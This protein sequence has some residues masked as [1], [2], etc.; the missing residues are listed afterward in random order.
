MANRIGIRTRLVRLSEKLA[1]TVRPDFLVLY[2]TRK[3]GETWLS[4]QKSAG[5]E[6]L[7]IDLGR[8]S[9][10]RVAA[11]AR[12]LGLLEGGWPSADLRPL[13]QTRIRMWA[14][15]AEILL[16]HDG[17]HNGGRLENALLLAGIRYRLGQHPPRLGVKSLAWPRTL[18]SANSFD[19]E[20]IERELQEI[21]RYIR[22]FRIEQRQRKEQGSLEPGQAAT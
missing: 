22:N 8:I 6:S 14:S 18:M 17:S 3:T 20:G 10:N 2:H 9:E 7:L 21:E 13:A 19:T 15:A 16:F 12:Q 5:D 4:R 1:D 11:L